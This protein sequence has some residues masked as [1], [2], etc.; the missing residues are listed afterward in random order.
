MRTYTELMKLKTFEERFEYLKLNGAVGA[1]TFGFDRYVNQI[2]YN[3]S[4]W[5]QVRNKIILRDCDV[6]GVLDLGHPDHVITG[7]VLIHHMNPIKIEDII[8]KKDYIL[9]PEFLICT[10]KETH[11]AIHYGDASLLPKQTLIERSPFDTCP[12]RKGD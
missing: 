4:A 10:S 9:D 12:W 11:N 8:D 1:R 5:R 7:K 3:S 6:Y 2:F